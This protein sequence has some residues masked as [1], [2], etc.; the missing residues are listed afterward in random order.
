MAFARFDRNSD[1][2]V[3]ADTRGGYTCERCPDVGHQ[4][5]CSSSTEMVAH[6]RSYHRAKGHRVP[7]EAIEELQ[8]DVEEP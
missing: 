4:Y 3:Y 1:V 5:R 6:L 7:D 2:Y 8:R